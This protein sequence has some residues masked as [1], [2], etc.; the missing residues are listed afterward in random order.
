MREKKIDVGAQ[1]VVFFLLLS[2]NRSA[3]NALMYGLLIISVAQI[4]FNGYVKYDF[5]LYVVPMLFMPELREK[6]NETNKK[7]N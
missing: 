1:N 5:S 2:L 4:A 7:E 6:N 3:A